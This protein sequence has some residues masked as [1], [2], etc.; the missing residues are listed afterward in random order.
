M[1]KTG[2]AHLLEHMLFKGTPNF[3][4]PKEIP[5]ALHKRGADYNGST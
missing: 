2:M 4:G 5:N 1:A 3:S